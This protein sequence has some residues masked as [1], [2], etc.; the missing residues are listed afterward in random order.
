MY[1]DCNITDFIGL[2]FRKVYYDEDNAQLIFISNTSRKFKMLHYSDCCESVTLD[3]IIGELD[4]LIGVPILHAACVSNEEQWTFYHINTKKG[5]VTLRWFSDSDWYSS[6]ISIVE[7][8]TRK[9][10]NK[11]YREQSYKQIS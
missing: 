5:Y 10:I 8:S 6:E 4:F 2:I 7:E 9:T 11:F 1:K 3:D